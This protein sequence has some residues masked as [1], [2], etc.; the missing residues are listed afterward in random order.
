MLPLKDVR[1]VKYNTLKTKKYKITFTKKPNISIYNKAKKDNFC[2]VAMLNHWK[3]LKD[4]KLFTEYHYFNNE[5]VRCFHQKSAQ[6]NI[7]SRI[8]I[9]VIY[10]TGKPVSFSRDSQG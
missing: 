2:Y 5:G 7:H 3:F 10:E 8:Q 1:F 4:D 6:W 9:A